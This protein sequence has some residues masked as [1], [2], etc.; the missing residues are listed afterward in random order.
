M[1]SNPAAI[2]ILKRAAVQIFGVSDT[3]KDVA[4]GP[5]C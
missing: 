4:T 3:L 5:G 1:G 2:N